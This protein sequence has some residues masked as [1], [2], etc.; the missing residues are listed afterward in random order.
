MS[1]AFFVGRE[2]REVLRVSF[3][4]GRMLTGHYMSVAG[5]HFIVCQ[6]PSLWI[7]RPFDPSSASKADLACRCLTA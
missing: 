1:A 3:A 7:S 2:E 4:D 6:G 5:Q